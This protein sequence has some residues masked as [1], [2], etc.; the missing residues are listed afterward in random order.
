[1]RDE[2]EPGERSPNGTELGVRLSIDI[3]LRARSGGGGLRVDLGGGR[4]GACRGGS[5]GRTYTS[6]LNTGVGGVIIGVWTLESKLY[7]EPVLLDILLERSSRL[8]VIF[9]GN[10]LDNLLPGPSLATM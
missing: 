5:T 2:L 3:D 4:G 8:S 10:F 9:G 1:M 6:W 7:T